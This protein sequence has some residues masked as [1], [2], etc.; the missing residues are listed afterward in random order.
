MKKPRYRIKRAWKRMFAGWDDPF[1][2][3]VQ[4][5]LCFNIWIPLRGFGSYHGA[6]QDVESRSKRAIPTAYIYPEPQ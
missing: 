3:T 4:R 1:W 5:R 6:F 2:Y